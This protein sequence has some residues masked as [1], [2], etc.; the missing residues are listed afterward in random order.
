MMVR[1]EAIAQVGLMDGDYYMYCEEIDW[2]WRM[3]RAGWRSLCV[4]QAKVVHHSGRST[5][6]APLAS[7]VSLWTSRARLYRRHHGP[8]TRR[9]AFQLVKHGMT[10]LARG[11]PPER[12]EA[13]REIV[14]TWKEIL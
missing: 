13:C 1:G 4:P 12:A 14:Q 5:A 9:L 8:L 7:F 6:Q 2:C 3:R 11:A 10:R